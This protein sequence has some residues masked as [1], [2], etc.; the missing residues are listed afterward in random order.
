M[1]ISCPSGTASYGKSLKTLV[2]H[3]SLNHGN[4]FIQ[5]GLDR[6]PRTYRNNNSY[7]S[8]L[9]RDHREYASEPL[10]HESGQTGSIACPMC[11]HIQK[12]PTVAGHLIKHI[13]AGE[14]V[15]CPFDMCEAEY[16]VQSSLTSHLSRVHGK[17]FVSDLKEA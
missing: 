17:W 9:Y 15:I 12:L 6:C 7:K 8:H 11:K 13:D 4:F 2:Q 5:C 3:I 16:S 14:P 1:M 10:I